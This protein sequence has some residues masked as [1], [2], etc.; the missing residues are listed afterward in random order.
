MKK[1]NLIFNNFADKVIYTT[2]M[3]F[4]IEFISI[5]LKISS[6][7]PIKKKMVNF[8]KLNLKDIKNAL[9]V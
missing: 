2:I 1:R 4:I 3:I 5:T 8:N 6:N 9:L 7:K